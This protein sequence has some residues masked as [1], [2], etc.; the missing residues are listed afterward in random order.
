MYFKRLLIALACAFAVLFPLNTMAVSPAVHDSV[1]NTLRLA[2]S[3]ND[4]LRV[5]YDI[6]DTAP[7]E[8]R[9]AAAETLYQMAKRLDNVDVQL[10][11]LRTL[12]SLY[13][14]NDSIL[15]E[16][17]ERVDKLP[18]SGRQQEIKTFIRLMRV[19]HWATNATPE[20]CADMLF[21]E[22]SD[23][24]ETEKT[25]LSDKIVHLYS[26]C[27][28]LG[29]EN[30]G[31]M[32]MSYISQLERL[33]QKLPYQYED[34]R[35]HFYKNA[36]RIYAINNSAKRSVAAN[37]E[38]VAGLKRMT[39][40]LHK[41]GRMFSH[42]D[43][44][45]Y[46]AYIGILANY[47]VLMDSE[48]EDLYRKVHELMNNN[49]EVMN[50]ARKSE[51]AEMFYNMAKKNYA[52]AFPILKR[53]VD[54]PAHKQYR[55]SLLKM[56]IEASEAVGDQATLIQA[57]KDYSEDIERQ[58]VASVEDRMSELQVVYGVNSLQR[59]RD[60]LEQER[61]ASDLK[62]HRGIMIGSIV[63]LIILVIAMLLIL[64][65]YRRAKRLSEELKN[66][67]NSLLEERD[68]LKRAQQKL[69]M[70]RDKAHKATE[71]KSDFVNSMSR[72]VSAPL[73]AIVEY[74]Q[75]IV[76]NMDES[77]R[78]YLEGFAEVVTL[79]AEL[80][81]TLINNALDVSVMEKD[82]AVITSRPVSV[83]GMCHMALENVRRKVK[84]SVTL[85]FAN[86]GEADTIVST[87]PGRVEQ[88]LL[89]LL[90]N[91]AKF[92]DEGSIT[93]S[94]ESDPVA[95]T[96]NFAV[97]DTGIGIPE[98]KEQVIFQRFEKLD[99]HSQGSGLGLYIC[100]LV[101]RLLGGTVKVDT[102]YSKGA[103]FIFTIPA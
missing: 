58:L 56:L 97:T 42:A 61:H 91:A 34:I 31:A 45:E 7:P 40:R 19:T 15:E 26:V 23:Y 38:L 85:E 67:N 88:V 47:G 69:I 92:T 12:A 39:T 24:K 84:P 3:P 48:I 70:A 25:S 2:K 101:A 49:P 29:N 60:M 28:Y 94:Y 9:T 62:W 22:L 83:Q 102:T 65:V 90:G 68:K 64:R 20:E 66:A 11:M 43:F 44:S 53:Q 18:K 50:D 14:I 17:L 8:K 96:L 27:L 99:S 37:Y 76:D 80:L 54:N 33:V 6:Y 16:Q 78:K 13:M 4:S 89:N 35:N 63:A 98:G 71:V 36:A 93:L 46:R 5:M 75:F 73:T 57:L 51:G 72:E 77:R 30:R 86:A 79:S 95:G 52:V 10:D 87:D 103:R 32:L 41:E 74:S 1:V 59:E 55:T 82:D 21:K 100:S 81:Q